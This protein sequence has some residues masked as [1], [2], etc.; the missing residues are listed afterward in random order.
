M[1]ITSGLPNS[2]H[3]GHLDYGLVLL[4]RQNHTKTIYLEIKS[5][6]KSCYIGVFPAL[7]SRISH[8]VGLMLVLSAENNTGTA[9]DRVP[10]LTTSQPMNLDACKII[11]R[12]FRI[13]HRTTNNIFRK[14]PMM[15]FRCA[16]NLKDLFRVRSSLPQDLPKHPTGTGP[17][18]VHV[19][20]KFI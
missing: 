18:A 10:L 20:C 1:R 4:W 6:L 11:S 13:L 15:A 3:S 2:R 9:N 14:P 12:N 17:F 8:S 7:F 5:N 16:K 19:P